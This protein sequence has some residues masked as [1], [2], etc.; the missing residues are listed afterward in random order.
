MEKGA[1]G[2]EFIHKDRPVGN[3]R[4]RNKIDLTADATL[5]KAGLMQE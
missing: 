2:I 1:S 5:R 4:I 3:A